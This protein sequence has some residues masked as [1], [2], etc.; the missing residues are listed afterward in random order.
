MEKIR[1][2]LKAKTCLKQL[3]ISNSQN[4][5]E[6]Y[7][8]YSV[9]G[10]EVKGNVDSECAFCFF[11]LKIRFL[12]KLELELLFLCKCHWYGPSNCR[13]DLSIGCILLPEG[14]KLFHT[15]SCVVFLWSTP[16]ISEVIRALSL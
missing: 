6:T 15:N 1:F 2:I 13:I 8:G 11:W 10:L 4:W 3:E 12:G 9:Q 14:W 5:I 16:K 7:R